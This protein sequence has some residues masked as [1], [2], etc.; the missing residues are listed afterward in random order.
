MADT[1]HTTN[2]PVLSVDDVTAGHYVL[3]ANGHEVLVDP[4]N[5]GKPGDLV[6]LWPK[7]KPPA[8]VRR[9]ARAISYPGEVHEPAPAS[10]RYYFATVGGE[11][12]DV[13]IN[14]VAQIHKIIG[15]L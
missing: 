11:M 14:K 12:I 2:V 10:Q 6:V 9:L 15:Y 3:R 5:R 7:R 13:P 8:I 4:A 1:S